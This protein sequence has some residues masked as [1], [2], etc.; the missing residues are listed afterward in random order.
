MVLGPLQNNWAGFPSWIFILDC[1]HS[2]FCPL[3]PGHDEGP[4]SGWAAKGIVR[5]WN[6]RARESP[7]QVSEPD[8][9]QLSQD[10]G[11]GTLAM[12]TLPDNRTRVVVSAGGTWRGSEVGVGEVSPAAPGA[13]VL[14]ADH[15]SFVVGPGGQGGEK[16]PRGG[17][18]SRARNGS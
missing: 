3:L 15:I 17:D 4:G 5:G 2:G 8:R 7:G 18:G 6:R 14:H 10:L 12:D 13:L 9:T 11:G 16:N 1:W